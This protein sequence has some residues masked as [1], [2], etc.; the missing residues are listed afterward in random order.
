MDLE[1]L[2]FQKVKE[3]YF[4]LRIEERN[5][6]SKFLNKID[7]FEK[8]SSYK[9]SKKYKSGSRL[10]D[11]YDLNNW[12]WICVTRNQVNFLISLQTFDRNPATQDLHILMDRIGI[13]AYVGE[14]SSQDAQEKMMITNLEL[15]LENP[16][17]NK[18]KQILKDLSECDLYRLQAQ[19]NDIC[20]RHG[21][22]KI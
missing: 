6:I 7:G 3:K 1:L 15:P 16:E 17:L 21:L 22:V 4:E 8:K 5:K 14:Y 2:D 12:L 19:Y 9:G 13:Y 11:A 18:L 10:E 20:D